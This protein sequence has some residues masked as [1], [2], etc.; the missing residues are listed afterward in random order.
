MYFRRSG[1]KKLAERFVWEAVRNGDFNTEDT[2]FTEGQIG[3]WQ[4]ELTVRTAF[5]LLVKDN[6]Q[7]GFVDLDFAFVFDETEFSE[8]V[9]EEIDAGTRGADHFGQ[10]FL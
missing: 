7:Q 3:R 9:H 10:G 1:R 8:F 2:E 5:E 6:G 4:R